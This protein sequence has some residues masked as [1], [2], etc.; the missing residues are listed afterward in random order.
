MQKC[1]LCEFDYENVSLQEGRCPQCGSIVEWPEETETPNAN[2]NGNGNG[3]EVALTAIQKTLDFPL[4]V[5]PAPERVND[6]EVVA[7]NVVANDLHEADIPSTSLPK[8]MEQ[9]WR[10]SIQG[11]TDVRSTLKGPNTGYTVSDSVFAILPREVRSPLT[12]TDKPVDYELLDVIGQGGVGVVYAARQASIDRTVAI[13]MLKEEYRKANEHQEKFLAEAVLTGELD[14]PNIV[15][16]YDLGR[17][18]QGELFYSMKNVIGTPWDRVIAQKSVRENLEILLKVADAVAFAHSRSVVHRDLKPENVMLGSF[19]EVLVMDWGIAVATE[20]FRRTSSILRSQAMG[21]TPAYMAPELAKGPMASIG[22][23]ADIYL[24]GAILFEILTGFPPHYGNNVMEC[25]QNAAENIIRETDV[26]GELMEI[27]TRAMATLP[28]RRYRSVKSFQ[29]AVRLYQS[30]SESLMLSDNAETEL[31]KAIS[32]KDYQGFSRAVFAF[33]E[34]ISLWDQNT[35]AKLGLT[36]ARAAYAETA[37]EKGDYDLGLSLLEESE[38]DHRLMIYKL[39]TAIAERNARQNRLKTIRK[40][41]I[42]LTGFIVI[43]GSIGMIVILNLNRELLAVVGAKELALENEVAA[44][45]LA[46]AE[47]K[48][49]TEAGE[50]AEKQRIA[51]VNAQLSA[52]LARLESIAQRQQ[53]EESSY[54]AEIG[55]VG[56]SI[57]QNQFSIASEILSQQETSDAKSKIRHWE[58]GRHQ[59]VVQGGSRDDSVQS[60]VTYPMGESI[61]CIDRTADGKWIAIGKLTGECELW[62]VGEKQSFA[63]FRHGRSLSDLDFNSDG[64]LIV[65]SGVDDD[66][67][68]TVCIWRLQEG[69]NPVAERKMRMKSGPAMAV[70]FSNDRNSEYVA[71]GDNK[72]IGRIWKWRE[73]REVVLLGHLDAFTSIEFSP[74]NEHVVSSSNDGTVRL[75]KSVDGSEVQQFSGHEAPVLNATFAPNGRVIASGGAD[76]RILLWA[77]KPEESRA[78]RVE[79][80]KKQLQGETIPKQ[81]FQS[82]EGHSGTVQEVSFSLDGKRLVSSA[83]DNEVFIW[84]VPDSSTTQPSAPIQKLRGHGGWVRACRLSADGTQ[85]FS[86]SDDRSWKSWQLDTYREKL[87]LKTENQAILDARHSPTGEIIATGHA[88]GTVVLWNS[89]SG[90]RIVQLSDGHE[91]LT[92]RARITK[93]GK[94]I[95]TAAGDNTLR[96]W[97]LQRGV[98]LAVMESA[99]RDG[100]F[101]ISQSGN[102][103][104]AG[105]D[106]LGV[107]IWDLDSLNEPVRIR[108]WP[109]QTSEKEKGPIVSPA[110]GVAISD[111]GRHA[112]VCDKSG[113]VEF[114]DVEQGTM[115]TRIFGHSETVVACFYLPLGPHAGM[116]PNAITVSSDGSVAWWDGVTGQALPRERLRHFSA[117]QLAT[118]SPTGRFLATYASLDDKKA[119]LWMW[120]MVTGENLATRDLEDLLVQDMVFTSG[121]SPTVYVTTSNLNDSQKRIWQWNGPQK[122]WNATG[123]AAM[124]PKSLFGAVPTE[125]DSN[126]LT[127]GG[128][129]ARLWRM[130]DGKELKSYRPCSIIQS[131]CFDSTGKFLAAASED[132]TAVIWEVAKTTS[133]Q[134]LVGGHTGA[135]RDLAFSSDDQSLYTTGADGRIVVWD[136]AKGIPTLP[137]RISNSKIVGNSLRLSPDGKVMAVGCDDSIIRLY[138]AATLQPIK[139]LS[140]HGAAVHCLAFSSDSQWIVSGSQDQTIRVW[141]VATGLEI[142]KLLGHS[143]P[144]ASVVFSSD[145]LRVLSSSQDTTVKLWDIGRMTQSRPSNEQRNEEKNDLSLGVVLSLEYHA[146]EATVAEFSPDGRTILTAGIDGEA[147][148]WPSERIPPAIRLSN[149]NLT[150]SRRDDQKRIDANAVLC[151]PGTLDLDGA[152]MELKFEEDGTAFGELVV[153][154]SDG[155]FSIQDRTLFYQP[156]TQRPIAIG[157]AGEGPVLRF[158]FNRLATHA[159]AE[160]L[161]QHLAFRASEQVETDASS[162]CD[163]IIGIVDRE[164]RSGNYHPERVRIS[165]LIES[166]QKME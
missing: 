49:A 21:G 94:L 91:Y 15:P 36:R 154:T 1:A 4:P 163:V 77:V 16:I 119:R 151:Q 96:L 120:D 109:Q 101:S 162:A 98:Q 8:D 89:K 121:E 137:A 106:E 117:V 71:A 155:R 65:S 141:S 66:N 24:L 78:K 33:D 148:L 55:L 85:A 81:S 70:A 118:L 60:V 142:G 92:N 73:D 122:Q 145:G 56:A 86:G 128:R 82:L 51:A 115:A 13:K 139:D 112:I 152:T 12:A 156:A 161:I 40:V 23:A 111:D 143:A 54:F 42:G 138:D 110:T 22:P 17:N 35:G 69:N 32:T 135:I 30:H 53:A 132:G 72:R 18:N 116:N 131:I 75:W 103:L 39:R 165:R 68:G 108:N 153:D 61:E 149:P 80:V 10:N 29:A 58:W 9:L 150:I 37:Y 83:N 26:T 123:S 28:R 160:E 134:K 105:G 140:G 99:G 2:G 41:A 159:A 46:K 129:G 104:V 164:G 48:K 127:Y 67:S 57:E 27:A 87:L 5:Q 38:E 146:S 64:S 43:A 97:D 157:I 31:N 62:R 52:E 144:L 158:A 59:F 11:T 7:Q 79:V 34:A 19:G 147:V 6:Q 95:A 14:H 93:E 74:D 107:A 50:R 44:V 113:T 25:V 136:I 20:G 126:L 76:Q 102:W 124:T 133:V 47:E 3:N 88:D 130:K 114:W 166:N 125:N 84:N 100:I 90:E 63:T 45:K